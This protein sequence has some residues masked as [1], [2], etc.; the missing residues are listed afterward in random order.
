MTWQ[1][2]GGQRCSFHLSSRRATI[3]LP[4]ARAYKYQSKSDKIEV[5]DSKLISEMQ[6]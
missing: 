5:V 4:D 6:N 3:N 2:H 1:Q